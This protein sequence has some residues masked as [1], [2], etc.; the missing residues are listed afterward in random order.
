MLGRRG[1]IPAVDRVEVPC[2]ALVGLF[3]HLDAASERRQGHLVVIEGPVHVG[4]GGDVGGGVGLAQQ[5]DRDLG[6]GQKFVP[7]VPQ[8]KSSATPAMM[9]K[10]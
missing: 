5:I 7:L 3:M 1:E 9:L 8:G 10:K 4:V 6:L 2:A